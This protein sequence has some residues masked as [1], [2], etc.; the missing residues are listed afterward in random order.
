MNFPRLTSTSAVAL[1]TAMAM[2]S[3]PWDFAIY[4]DSACGLTPTDCFS[5]GVPQDCV[6]LIMNH[7]VFESHNMGLCILIV[8]C[9]DICVHG[10]LQ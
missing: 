6:P 7:E 1:L 8:F 3:K 5:S 2:V 4:P 9:T 10:T